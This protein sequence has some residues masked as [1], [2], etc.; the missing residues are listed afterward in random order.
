L[1]NIKGKYCCLDFENYYSVGG[2]PQRVQEES[3]YRCSTFYSYPYAKK[4]EF[5][6]KH[7]KNLRKISLII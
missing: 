4:N 6:E 5:C 2:I 1:K 3:M 7:I